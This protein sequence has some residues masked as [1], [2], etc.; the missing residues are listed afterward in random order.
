MTETSEGQGRA[1]LEGAGPRTRLSVCIV[2]L[3]ALHL[4]AFPYFPKLKHAN[5][6]PRVLTTQEIV[7]KGTFQ[8]NE[9]LDELGSRADISTTPAGRQ[10][11]NKAPGLTIL[12]TAVYWPVAVVARAFGGT[13][14]MALTTWLLR[15][16]MVTLPAVLF[17][18]LFRRMA[19]RFAP[20]SDAARDAALIAYAFGS[21][22]FPYALLFMS[23]VPAAVAV[24]AAFVVASDEAHSPAPTRW[25]GSL[26]IGAALGLA[27]FVEYQAIFAAFFIGVF[28]LAKSPRGAR[29]R[30]V[31]GMALGA[32]PFLVALGFYHQ[33]CFGSPFRTGYAYSVDE[34]NRVGFMGIVGP[35]AKAVTQLFTRGNNGLLVFSPWVLFSVVGAVAIARSRELRAR[36]GA[37]ALVASA[38]GL[39]YLAFVGSLA[40][41]FGRAGWSVGPR[42]IAVAIPFFGWLAAAGLAVC[43]KHDE[44]WVPALATIFAAVLVN[45]LAA[46]TYPHW[47][48]QFANPVFEISVR[49]LREGHAPH[50]IGTALGLRGLA[51][52]LPLYL[53]IGAAITWGLHRTGARLGHLALALVLGALALSR[54]E[55]F[56]QTKEPV[57]SEMWSYVTT[58]Y[59]P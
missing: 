25:R 38:I 21:L 55:N 3:M 14:S 53:T 19:G 27:M 32:L 22:A 16:T 35:S 52:L 4:Y 15:V 36:I 50:S 24:G 44:L 6:L 39:T 56:S 33:A 18:G 31:V 58:T 59:E 28:V 5:E 49:L 34:A 48:T 47:P 17:L 30:A 7:H 8:L 11:Q 45:V 37:E 1:R 57:R 23:H 41:E 46:T 12:A 54:F 42:Y 43:R 9:R 40:P 26:L 51:S 13:P 29:L 20:D 10:Y 2:V